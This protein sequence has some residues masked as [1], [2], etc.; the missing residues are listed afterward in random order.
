MK[1]IVIIAPKSVHVTR[2]LNGLDAHDL[3]Y[4]VITNHELHSISNSKDRVCLT[5]FSLLNISGIKKIRNFLLQIKPDILHI[6]QANSVAF[7][8]IIA[9]K[10]TNLKPKVIL[11]AWGSDILVLP[12][13]GYFLRRMVQFNLLNSD[14]ITADAKYVLSQIQDLLPSA[15]QKELHL[16]NFGVAVS[17]FNPELLTKKEDLIL[18]VRLHKD[19]YNIDKIILGFISAVKSGALPVSY[20]LVVAASGENTDELKRLAQN[21][22]CNERIK[23]VGMLDYDELVGY[24]RK[25]KIMISIPES[26]AS[27]SSLFEAMMYGCIPLVSDLPANKEWITD[28]VNGVVAIADNLYLG[29]SQDLARTISLTQD[30]ER[31]QQIYRNNYETILEQANHE[32]SIGKFIDLYQ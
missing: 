6:H 16:I 32:A 29:L 14:V 7:N 11:T 10:M 17:P 21:S 13:K 3:E 23:F 15:N 22:I 26:D 9:L 4:Y 25:A 12:H 31:Y 20:N 1:K 8:T 24:Y 19:L 18:S 27:A 30:T 2:F 5:K 28:E